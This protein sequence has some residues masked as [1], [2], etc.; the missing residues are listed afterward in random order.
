MSDIRTLGREFARAVAQ[1]DRVKE[2]IGNLP[3]RLTPGSDV[4]ISDDKYERDA[5]PH[6]GS[7]IRRESDKQEG[8]IDDMILVR[9]LPGDSELNPGIGYEKEEEWIPG[10]PV[11]TDLP[12]DEDTYT[13]PPG[14]AGEAAYRLMMTLNES[15]SPGL[16]GEGWSG[17]PVGGGG[18][19][20]YGGWVIV[21]ERPKRTE[22][23]ISDVAVATGKIGQLGDV[24][25]LAPDDEMGR[26]VDDDIYTKVSIRHD[27]KFY[28]DEWHDGRLYLTLDD[29]TAAPS[30][31]GYKIKTT[32]GFDSSVANTMS[33]HEPYES[34]NWRPWCVIPY[35]WV[36]PPAAVDPVWPH[37]PTLDP[38]LSA[39]GWHFVTDIDVVKFTAEVGEKMFG[40]DME[41]GDVMTKGDIECTTNTCGL[42]LWDDSE[43]PV[44]WRVTID[45]L[46][47]LQT[48]LV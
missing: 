36:A 4:P 34:V 30:A 10:S 9:A 41:T 17:N 18:Q 46:G 8:R 3:D 42:I 7:P 16:G 11:S 37:D 47:D 27:A 15:F 21:V 33:Q 23:T 31:W 45:H 22:W 32:L 39:E 1:L 14:E 40:V 2:R 19:I 13:T 20:D 29:L 24:F 28:M 38:A 25:Y 43:I 6:A 5:V 12:W 26:T 44:A 48:E 35:V